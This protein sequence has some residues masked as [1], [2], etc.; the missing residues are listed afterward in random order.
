MADM[1]ETLEAK[2]ARLIQ[3][4]ATLGDLRRGSLSVNYFTRTGLDGRGHPVRDGA[5]TTNLGA[6]EPAEAF[7]QGLYAEAIRRGVARAP[8]VIVLG[9]GAPW[10]WGLANEH[11][12]GAIQIMDL[13]HA[14]EHLGELGQLVYGPASPAAKAWAAACGQG[15]P[16][17]RTSTRA[18]SSRW[19]PPSGA[20]APGGA[21]PK[22]GGE[23]SP[24]RPGRPHPPRP[25]G[26]IA[27]R[28]PGRP[29]GGPPLR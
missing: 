9:D 27:P 22:R 10:I 24:R 15:T 12:P 17:A 8:P 28:P 14:R 26:P 21:K 23:S 2:R 20:C 16:A 5:S 13:Y 11:F 3:A 1:L 4:L 18:R 29:L 19:R 25:G 7:G 6:I